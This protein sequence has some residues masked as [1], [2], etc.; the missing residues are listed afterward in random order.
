VERA[1]DRGA[2][3]AVAVVGESERTLSAVSTQI[4]RLVKMALVLTLA[5]LLAEYA[6]SLVVPALRSYRNTD[7]LAFFFVAV[8]I[9]SVLAEHARLP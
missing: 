1:D 5:V 7:P 3:A 6:A 9:A 2:K 4:R 8:A